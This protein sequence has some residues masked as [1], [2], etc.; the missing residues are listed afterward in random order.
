[1]TDYVILKLNVKNRVKFKIARGI[2][3]NRKHR[4]KFMVATCMGCMLFSSTLYAKDY[5]SHWA[6]KTIDTWSTSGIIQGEGEGIF[7]PDGHVTRGQLAAFVD[8]IF[9]YNIA[10]ST[11]VYTDIEVGSWYE[12]NAL[13]VAS[14]GIM[15]LPGNTFLPQQKVTREEVAYAMA[16]AYKLRPIVG[17]E[18]SF[19]DQEAISKWATDGIQALAQKGYLKGYPDGSFQP[20]APITRAEFMTL[21]D[22]MTSQYINAPGT[23]TGIQPGN[24]VINEGGVT[25][26]DTKIEGN[27]YL[28]EGIG[29]GE[30]RLDKVQVTG[31]VYIYGGK[32]TLSG[33]YETIE[34]ATTALVTFE[35]GT[36]K[37][38]SVTQ[39]GAKVHLKKATTTDY[40]L[41][42]EE[43]EVTAEGTV[44]KSS[45][46]DLESLHIESAG[47]YMGG[48]FVPVDVTD[49]V[50]TIN[51]QKLANE[52]MSD[53]MD[54]L[55]INTNKEGAYLSG[56]YGTGKMMTNTRYAFR[57][58]DQELGMIE[59]MLDQVKSKSSE[60]AG[61][62]NSLGVSADTVF[63][64]LT[65]DGTISLR[66]M[67]S[68]YDSVNQMV[69]QFTGTK[70]ETSY[71]FKR[72][73]HHGTDE[74][75]TITIR[76]QIR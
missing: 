62:A 75:V 5:A 51:L 53:I 20:K 57:R 26:K 1:M 21:I 43:A 41:V 3:L 11:R 38:V 6:E 12:E 70:L 34:V 22:Q 13:S 10:E 33:N 31:D 45:K 48:T 42:T 49:H 24:V 54:G 72:K 73:L 19:T 15:Y 18:I 16:K 55:M 63:S 50:V 58:A 2:Q 44:K 61:I 56:H 74:P 46:R 39:E 28:A 47:V 9:E 40:L 71:E 60:L 17:E 76:L 32:V 27:L 69:Q 30:V 8:R 67:M 64:M 52:S 14:N 59:D 29:E 25:L 65:Q 23:Y 4:T 7:N 36:A 37:Q 66:Y 68:Q 35:E